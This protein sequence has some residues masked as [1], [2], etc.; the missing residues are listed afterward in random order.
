MNKPIQEAG[1]TARKQ[2]KAVTD[3]VLGLARPGTDP[4]GISFDYQPAVENG[5]VTF[6]VRIDRGGQISATDFEINLG[7]L[8]HDELEKLRDFLAARHAGLGDAYDITRAVVWLLD[9]SIA[10]QR[11]LLSKFDRDSQVREL[12]LFAK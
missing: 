3:R 7:K 6:Q 12:L 2:T 8:S 4:V 9:R 5:C 1:N 10:Q 11:P